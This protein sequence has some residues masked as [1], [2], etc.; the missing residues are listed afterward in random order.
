VTAGCGK[1]TQVRVDCNVKNPVMF[2]GLVDLVQV[3]AGSKIDI[4]LDAVDSLS[5][6]PS[7][8][9]DS[10]ADLRLTLRSRGG[11]RGLI[12]GRKVIAVRNRRVDGLPRNPDAD[13][14]QA[15]V[16]V[17]E[18]IAVKSYGLGIRVG[19]ATFLGLA[20]YDSAGGLLRYELAAPDGSSSIVARNGV[21]GSADLNEE[22]DVTEREVARNP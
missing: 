22:R 7:G 9:A 18:E 1:E 6:A 3:G 4:V 20:L 2:M 10:L 19:S 13:S 8:P 11:W 5:L 12:G 16:Q 15:V 21:S 17:R 14:S